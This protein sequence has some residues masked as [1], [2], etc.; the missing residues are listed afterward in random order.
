LKKALNQCGASACSSPVVAE[1]HRDLATVYIVGLKQ[2]AKGKTELKQALKANP[3]LQLSE[4]FATPELRKLFKELGGHEAKEEEPEEE[5]E[6]EKPKEKSCE[7]GE[8]DCLEEE[9]AKEADTDS[10]K[11]SKNWLGLHFEQDLLLYSE[12]SQVCAPAPIE[13]CAHDALVT[14]VCS[15]LSR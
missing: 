13:P 8:E 5:P 7:S 6:K 4:D 14:V 10:S 3:D 15:T 9:P 1:L 2:N 11:G 12:Q